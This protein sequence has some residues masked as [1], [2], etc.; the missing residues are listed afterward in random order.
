MTLTAEQKTILIDTCN[1]MINREATSDYSANLREVA[2]VALSVLTI[3]QEPKAWYIRIGEGSVTTDP[4]EA[5]MWLGDPLYT[6]PATARI[7]GYFVRQRPQWDERA[8]WTQWKEVDEAS[9]A[10]IVKIIATGEAYCGW[11]YDT[12]ILYTAPPAP[13]LPTELLDAMDEIIRISDRDHAAWNRAKEAIAAYRE[14][15]SSD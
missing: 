12:R 7:A 10:D 6:V 3:S 4:D 15:G 1:A 9:Y 8:P 13:T 11:F 14:E 2:K 5:R